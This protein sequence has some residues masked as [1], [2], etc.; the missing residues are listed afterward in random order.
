MRRNPEGCRHDQRI[1]PRPAPQGRPTPSLVTDTM[2]ERVVGRIGNL[3]ETGMLLIAS[4]PLVEDALYQFRFLLPRR[5][6]ATRRRSRSA[7]ICCGWIA[8]ARPGSRG[9][10]SAS[11]RLT[12]DAGRPPARSGSTRPAASTSNQR[13]RRAAAAGR[14][15]Q[16]GRTPPTSP[17]AMSFR[18]TPV[19]STATTSPVLHART[20]D[21]ARARRLRSSR[22]AQRH[23]ALPGVRRPRLSVRGQSAVQGLA[24]ADARAGQLAGGD[25]GRE[26]EADLPTAVRLLARGAG[27]AERLVGRA[28]RHRHHPQARGGA[29]ASARERMGPRVARSSASRRARSAP[30]FRTI[31]QRSCEYLRI[32]PRL[33]DALRSRDDARG[34]PRRA[35]ARIAPPRRA[36]RDGASE[37]DI[38]LAYCAAA[39]QDAGELPYN[40]IVALNEHGAV[41]H[42]T[43]LDRSAARGRRAV[44]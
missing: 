33:Q 26:T 11:S 44:S 38:H 43:E 34:H 27:C 32:P 15:R 14:L 28:F 41:L 8:P 18:S 24:A 39:R 13:E 12:E 17:L 40:N 23:P 1:P 25:A 37:F 31:R 29:A 9:P 7:R 10:A 3:S 30:T 16:N 5:R 4:A 6:R 2:T 20:D 42:Y 36:F 35:C 21:R 22:R 19:R